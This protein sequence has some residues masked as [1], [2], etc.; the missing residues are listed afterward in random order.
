MRLFTNLKISAKIILGF[1]ITVAISTCIGAVSYFSL[2]N[3]NSGMDKLYNTS[4]I[5]IKYLGEIRRDFLTMRGDLYDLIATEEA[6]KRK[7]IE[8]KIR[9]DQA[10]M[11][12]TLGKYE[13]FDLSEDE[14][15]KVADFKSAVDIYFTN[16]KDIFMLLDARNTMVA[17]RKQEAA[18]VFS[19]LAI[20]ALNELIQIETGHAEET[21]VHG[22]MIFQQSSLLSLGLIIANIL[23]C[24]VITFA[25][26]RSIKMPL[27]K[28]LKLAE[29]ISL[30]DLT[31][32]IDYRSKDEIGHLVE[33]LNQT[34]SKLQSTLRGIQNASSTVSSASQQLSATTE[35]SNASMQEVTHGITQISEGAESNASAIEQISAALADISDKLNATAESSIQVSEASRQVKAAAENGGKLVVDM[36]ESVEN[37]SKSSGDI[38]AIMNELDTSAK[39]INEIVA[40]ITQISEQTN[41][42]ALN[43]AIEAARAGEQGRG[44]AVVADEVRKL[45]EQSKE[46]TQTI[47][48]MSRDIQ[49]KTALA[50]E[51]T[52]N[53]GILVNSA[54]SMARETNRHIQEIILQIKTV[55]DQVAGISEATVLQSSLT[56]EINKSIET[57]TVAIESQAGSAQEISATM[58]E[59]ASAMEEIGATAEE[60]ASMSADLNSQIAKFNI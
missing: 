1:S 27:Q 39:K 34:A 48:L 2:L 9:E 57:I 20:T 37:V 23:L 14:K 47:D 22:K 17:V 11:M 13:Q 36:A 33:T 35:E 18:H 24:L 53:S 52:K 45:A 12:N 28:S 26:T 10:M 7:D 43:A 8:K 54:S 32:R 38:A 25:I 59:Q 15:T 29:A 40:L 49:V 31:Q 55:V 42:L 58:Q 16:A 30:G 21:N 56:Q 50:S 41:L 51:K 46:A 6:A 4:L 19:D 60:L 3:V 5:P 44:F